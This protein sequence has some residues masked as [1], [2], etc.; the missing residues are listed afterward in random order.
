[1]KIFKSL[2]ISVCMGTTLCACSPQTANTE[3]NNQIT[4]AGDAWKWEKGTIVID[5]PERPA[6]QK[7]VLGLTTPKMEVVRVGFVGLGMRGPG[8]VS[9]FTHIPGTQIVAL[10]DYEASRAENCQEILKKASMPK[11]AIYSGET[12]YEELCK[13]DDIDL[14]YIAA[15]WLHH[16]PIARCAMENGKNVAIEVPSAMTLQ[17]CWDLVNLSEKTRKHCMILENCCYDWY[18]MNTLN[19]AQQGVFGEII[20]AQGAYIHDLSPFWEH[21]WKNGENDKLGWRLEYNMKHRGDVYATHGLGPVAQAMDIH[22]GDRVTTLVAMDTKSVIGKELVEQKTGKECNDFRNGD[23]TTTLLRTANGKVIEIQHNVMTPQPYNRLYQLTGSKGFANKYPV[24]GYALDAK[25]LNASG[26]QPKIDNLNAHGFLPKAEMDA[27]VEKYQHPILKKYGE[28]AKEV[29]GHGGMDFIMDSRL[30]Y[31]L[32]NGLPLDMDVYD[33]A[34]WCCLAELGQISM[35]NGCAAVAFPD[36][37]RG[38]W[39]VI[40]GY[41]HAY[42]SAEAEKESMEK[43]KA[44]T[45]KL[46]EQGAKEWAEAK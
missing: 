15:D 23:H 42:A 33:L 43:A 9:R 36:F 1:M 3:A 26:V 7:S 16:F 14:V 12:G 2:L 25:Q 28:I 21:Y 35:D 11:A 17:E 20:R 40:K 32:Q 38:E 39:N 37:T 5:T 30:V 46:K 41:K 22:R 19:M 24:E 13:R 44:F 29:G 31:C 45:A 27:L 8:A 4:T 6:G 18:E 10:C 34:E